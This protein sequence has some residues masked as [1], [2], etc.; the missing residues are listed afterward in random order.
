MVLVSSLDHTVVNTRLRLHAYSW[1]FCARFSKCCVA[2][3]QIC[4]G[5]F[6][7]D[8]T[9]SIAKFNKSNPFSVYTNSLHTNWEVFIKNWLAEFSHKIM[10]V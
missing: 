2:T 8:N 5:T 4:S 6:C 9:D 1:V 10:F 3:S 7:L